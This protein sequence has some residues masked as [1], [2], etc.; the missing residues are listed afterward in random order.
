MKVLVTGANGFIGKNLCA[1]LSELNNITLYKYDKS[2]NSS[3][4]EK[5]IINS[6]FIFHLAG[7]NRSESEEDFNQNQD[8]LS[9]ICS[10]L[11]KNNRST[12]ILFSSSIQASNESVYGKTKLQA[13]QV[14]KKYHAQT[15]ANIFIY[16]LP[17]VF[18]K[19]CRPNYNSVVA[20]FCNQACNN[21]E[22]SINNPNAQINLCYID[23]VIKSFISHINITSN[24]T[25][26]REEIFY[27]ISPIYNITV[28]DLANKI[29]T[30]SSSRKNMTLPNLYTKLDLNLYSTYL[31]YFDENSFSYPANQIED[32]RG[33]FAEIFKTKDNGQVSVSR[34]KPCIVR[35]NHWHNSKVEKFLVVEGK[36]C[37]SFR[38]INNKK[39]IRYY[40][41]GKKLEIVDIPPGYTHSIE[42]IGSSDLVT[43]IW[44]NELFDQEN[45]DTYQLS[46]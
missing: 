2:S 30:F 39:I 7:V 37:I 45:P 5:Y 35:G 21:Q 32:N 38:N 22:L 6:D 41:D 46:V 9:Y 44:A 34:T 42:N 36:A 17:N 40:V 4:L 27:N 8:F 23:D 31:S 11:Q 26:S 14:L 24:I 25:F 19:W 12:P 29:E 18:G 1:E 33:F 28:G 43:I 20:T 10:I 15:S 16:R 13:E 3:D